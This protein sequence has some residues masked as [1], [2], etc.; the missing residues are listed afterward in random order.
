MFSSIVDQQLQCKSL[1]NRNTVHIIQSLNYKNS[2]IDIKK[3]KYGYYLSYKNNNYN[4]SNYLKW[5]NKEI[6]DIDNNDIDIIVTYPL[7]L[8]SHNKNSINIHLGPYGYYM[9]YN[10]KNY[11]IHQNPP[12]TLDYCINIL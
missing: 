4:V 2:M 7:K 3:G 9:S 10:K 1:G 6:S 8:G 12:Y 5:K 11:K